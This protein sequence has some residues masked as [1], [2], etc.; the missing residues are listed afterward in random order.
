[1]SEEDRVRPLYAVFPEIVQN[2]DALKRLRGGR[3]GQFTRFCIFCNAMADRGA[4]GCAAG[5]L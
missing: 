4:R 1:M 3:M 5:T 2:D